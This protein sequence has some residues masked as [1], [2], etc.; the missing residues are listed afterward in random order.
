MISIGL[1]ILKIALIFFVRVRRANEAGG[2]LCFFWKKKQDSAGG[3][4]ERGRVQIRNIFLFAVLE[5]PQKKKNRKL[6]NNGAKTKQTYTP[7]STK[8]PKRAAR[9]VCRERSERGAERSGALRGAKRSAGRSEAE[10]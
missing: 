10:R 1:W 8:K 6:R 9:K 7:F 3:A 2:A 4:N 5:K